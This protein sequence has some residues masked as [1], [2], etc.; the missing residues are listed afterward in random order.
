MPGAGPPT[1]LAGAPR[2]CRQKCASHKPYTAGSCVHCEVGYLGRLEIDNAAQMSLQ[3][4]VSL[5]SSARRPGRPRIMGCWAAVCSPGRGKQPSTSQPY[6]YRAREDRRKICQYRGL[7]LVPVRGL[8]WAGHAQLLGP[9]PVL[10]GLP[11]FCPLA[12]CL[13]GEG[14]L[15]SGRLLHRPAARPDPAPS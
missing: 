2:P 4:H 6:H 14:P 5:L 8:L 12:R 13:R 11:D 10:L 1:P 7:Q 9:Y 15:L 3:T